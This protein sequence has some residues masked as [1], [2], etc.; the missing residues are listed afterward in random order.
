[1]HTGKKGDDD[2][3]VAT[4]CYHLIL[5]AFLNVWHGGILVYLST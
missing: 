2:G 3:L 4:Y 5:F 1:M